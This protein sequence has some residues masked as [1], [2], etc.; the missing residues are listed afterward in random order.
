MLFVAVPGLH[1]DGHEFAA[2]AVAEGASALVVERP[3][4][5]V[6]VPQLV[7]ERSQLALPV[8]A[9]WWEGW[10]G[11]EL[12]VVGGAGTDGKTASTFLTAAMLAAAAL[13]PPLL[14][15]L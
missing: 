3:V 14:R 12:G 15:P 4:G 9:A 6:D 1:H 10:P 11:R 7:V 5:G 13:P 2:Q 8:A